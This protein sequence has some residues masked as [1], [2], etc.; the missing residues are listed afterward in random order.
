MRIYLSEDPINENDILLY[1]CKFPKYT[2]LILMATFILGFSFITL[3][4]L[5]SI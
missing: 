3:C 5:F 4:V 1:R 2:G